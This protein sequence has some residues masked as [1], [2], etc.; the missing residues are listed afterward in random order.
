MAK[1]PGS[2]AINTKYL[3]PG[4]SKFSRE[5]LVQRAY[6]DLNPYPYFGF[7][8]WK[9]EEL[10]QYPICLPIQ[11][12][13]INRS[14]IW[15]FGK[16]IQIEFPGETDI[17]KE[18]R[19]YWT[20]NQCNSKL[21]PL[22]KKGG[23]EGD[24]TL[25]FSYDSTKEIP[26]R[27]QVYSNATDVKF[28]YDPLDAETVIMVRVQVPYQSLQ[29]G[30]WYWYREE[31]TKEMEVHY[32]PLEIA[33]FGVSN[34]NPYR[35]VGSPDPNTIDTAKEWKID[36]RNT[37]ANRLNVIPF[38][39][40]SNINEGTQFGSPDCGG[41]PR[42]LDRI[43]L[44]YWLMDR[45]N[46][47]AIDPLTLFIDL[48]PKE[49]D[50][51]DRPSKPGAVMDL[52]SV[53]GEEGEAPKKG[54][55]VIL[56]AQGKIREHLTHYADSL[57]EILFDV[58]GAV[59][60]RQADVTNKGSLTQSVLIQMYAP[61]L[62]ITNEKRKTYGEDGII[63]F[64]R[65]VVYGLSNLGVAPFNKLK[66]IDNLVDDK[67]TTNITWFSQFESSE[68]ELF[69]EFDR[70]DRE[71]EGGYIPTDII[72]KRVAQLEE[73]RLTEE[74]IEKQAKE[75][76]ERF[77]TER[78]GIGPNGEAI[79]NANGKTSPNGDKSAT[80]NKGRGNDPG[81]NEKGQGASNR[82]SRQQGRGNST[83]DAS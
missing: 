11:K 69:A 4:W 32:E 45:D 30:K 34:E 58:T 41:L 23:R 5:A 68:D 61:L 71:A 60:P 37:K 50:S 35:Y 36:T 56:E 76:D 82:K 16:E 49:G 1:T 53:D 20:A 47:L 77:E 72:V 62:E 46:Q 65:K 15:L 9:T 70:L 38:Q 10:G 75:V 43:H 48:E 3:P 78:T 19:K 28:F 2:L 31:W 29:N 14:A 8:S 66:G 74:Q 73:I 79:G 44:A 51:M 13:I 22:A 17:E 54:Q 52:K 6:Y 42:V 59:F 80:S 33:A 57:K 26:L 27:F 63:P 24:V 12:A 18:L 25:K 83:K 39:K 40:L 81:G 21:V 67:L 7:Q 55:A 64:L